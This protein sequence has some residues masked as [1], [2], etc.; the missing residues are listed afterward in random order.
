MQFIRFVLK[1]E[2]EG[3]SFD[4]GGYDFAGFEGDGDCETE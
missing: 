3:C 1:D 4:R 2:S